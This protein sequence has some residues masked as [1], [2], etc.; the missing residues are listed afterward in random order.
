MQTHCACS[1]LVVL[2]CWFLFHSWDVGSCKCIDRFSNNDGTVTASLAVS[3][4]HIAAGAESGVVNLYA[5][6]NSSFAKKP[7]RSIM[8]VPTAVDSLRF[9]HDGQILAMS[10]RFSSDCLKLMHV[11]SRTVFSN[12]PTSKTPLNY[13]FSMDFSPQSRY[14]AVGNDKGKCLLY[15]IRQYHT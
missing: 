6:N 7:I 8:N 15:K 5:T 9:N 2:T 10:S 13:V 3:D 14:F 1:F 12:W 11:P 4:Q